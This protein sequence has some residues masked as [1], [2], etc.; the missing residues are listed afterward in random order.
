MSSFEMTKI[1]FQ[2]GVDTVHEIALIPQGKF[3]IKQNVVD[4][5]PGFEKRKGQIKHHTTAAGTL[6]AITLFQTSKARRSEFHLWKQ[7]SDGAVVEATDN[8]P[9]VTTGAFGTERLAAVASALPASWGLFNDFTLMSD[10]VRQHQIYAGTNMRVRGFLVGG[11]PSSNYTYNV[12]AAWEFKDYSLEVTDGL[13]TTVAI[14]D[15]LRSGASFYI[16]THVPFTSINLTVTSANTNPVPLAGVYWNG[17]WAV[18]TGFSDG[19]EVSGETLAQSGSF[20]RTAP[21]DEIPC[22]L[23]GRYGYWVHFYCNPTPLSITI[24]R[25]GSTATATATNHGFATGS[26]VI[27]SGADQTEYNTGLSGA[28]I[29]NVTANTFD[30]T[31]SG[32]PAT[33]ATGTIT[34]QVSLSPT[35]RISEVTYTAGWQSV[36]N[37]CDGVLVSPIEALTAT[38]INSTT[39]DTI[40]TYASDAINI[41]GMLSTEY[42]YFSTTDPIE[43]VLIDVNVPNVGYAKVTG[44]T[45]IAF[46]DGG[47]G[48]N[49]YIENSVEANFVSA[50]FEKGMSITVSGST[51]NNFTA[52]IISVTP[53]RIYV[54]TATIVGETLTSATITAGYTANAVSVNV[55]QTWDGS[56]WASFAKVQ[57]STDG[58]S[59]GL[60]AP[61][62][63]FLNKATVAQETSNRFSTPYDAY[64]YR[65]NFTIAKVISSKANIGIQVMNFFDIDDFG[66][67]RVNAAWKDRM[68]YTFTS[69][70]SDIYISAKSAATVLNGK[71]FG[72]VRAGDGRANAVLAMDR[73]MN[74]LLVWQE[75]KG[76]LGGCTTLIQGYSPETYGKLI[77]SDRVGIMNSKSKA[78]VDGITVATLSDTKI[79]TLAFWLSRYGVMVTDGRY[80][81]VVSDDIQ[82]YFDPVRSECIRYGYESKM[83]LEF[84]AARNALRVGLVSGASATTPNIFP[85]FDLTDMA[86][87]FDVLGQNLSC[88]ANVE[89]ASGAI[90]M[91]QVGGGQ[92]GFVYELN[93]GLNDVS[94]AIDT[95]IALDINGFGHKIQC[96]GD[97]L[98]V[99]SQ[100]TGT[101]SRAFYLDGSPT[102]VTTD[103]ISMVAA[104]TS[105]PYAL[106]RFDNHH[107]VSGHLR[108]EWRHNTA[109]EGCYFEEAGLAVTQS[110][111]FP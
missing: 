77:I 65:M 80:V 9:T 101:V 71:D 108:I 43:G 27:V 29:S 70:P 1:P 104:V 53:T 52:T 15:N 37:L 34:A 75:E 59:L 68:C 55:I 99:K 93:N 111:D 12:D 81:S 51:S 72:I 50:G 95:K 109:S 105:S 110:A 42:V 57:A 73:F 11:S 4:R 100:T 86:W 66:N 85:V 88:M 45:N 106:G 74:E 22:F 67:G 10:G 8:P 90:P 16:L 18:M 21:S 41:G 31:V 28:V 36:E 48:V 24:T 58:V 47:A 25:S 94:T 32:T 89:A 98:R 92:D 87:G 40:N 76:S 56:A 20:T 5:H 97:I 64:W 13:S 6:E 49:D 69:F 46:V 19:S 79:A 78:V 44:T 35:V 26:K 23:F 82:N 30:Y 61:N 62:Y 54:P 38:K 60:T 84:D 83:W 107:S 7:M 33:P 96:R 39:P 103:T 17:D 102:A 63:F 91:L 2:G 14:L 3:S